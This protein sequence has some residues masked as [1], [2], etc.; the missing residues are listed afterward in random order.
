M[1][2]FWPMLAYLGGNWNNSANAGA[3]YW[4]W[5]NGVGT[6]SRS[7]GGRLFLVYL[8][9]NRRFLPCLLAKDIFAKLC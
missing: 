4:N 7:I 1:G 2:K 5:N 8:I 9:V 6:R 3:F